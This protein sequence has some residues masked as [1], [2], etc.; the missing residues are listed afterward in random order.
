MTTIYFTIQFTGGTL[1]G[2]TH[3][4]AMTFTTIEAAAAFGR[5]GRVCRKPIGGSPYRVVDSSFQD[6]RRA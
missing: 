4:S 6:Y 5:I 3:T 1:K 2:L